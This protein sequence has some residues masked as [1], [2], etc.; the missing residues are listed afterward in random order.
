[1]IM[2]AFAL[3]I[4]LDQL[5]PNKPRTTFPLK[6]TVN[7]VHPGF[8][9]KLFRAGLDIAD[10]FTRVKSRFGAFRIFVAVRR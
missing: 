8:P 5:S 6:C 4:V 9:L 3:K 1:M 2:Q 10:T 7:F